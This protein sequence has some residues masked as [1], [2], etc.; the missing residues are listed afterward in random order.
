[1]T[2]A[3][4][5]QRT[6]LRFIEEEA[7]AKRARVQIRPGEWSMVKSIGEPD[8][9]GGI[10]FNKNGARGEECSATSSSVFLGLPAGSGG[11][12]TRQNFSCSWVTLY[13]LDSGTPPQLPNT[14]ERQGLHP[15]LLLQTQWRRTALQPGNA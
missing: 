5:L 15:N 4:M 2:S 14:N 12:F 11:I 8:R 10:C 6:Y 3:E 13:S 1:M 9:R 7:S